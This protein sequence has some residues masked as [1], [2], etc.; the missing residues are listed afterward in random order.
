MSIFAFGS[1]GWCFSIAGSHSHQSNQPLECLL[2]PIRLCG[3]KGNRPSRIGTSE[4][5]HRKSYFSRE[6]AEK[7]VL[8]TEIE[9]CLHLVPILSTARLTGFRHG[10]NI[11]V[12]CCRVLE[13][14]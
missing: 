2:Q 11:V 9:C 7:V 14:D 12:N 13:Q 1:Y 3:F 6:F 8:Y 4:V 10:L 5:L